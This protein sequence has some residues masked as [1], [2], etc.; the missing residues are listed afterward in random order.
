[1]D[2][3][4]EESM[5]TASAVLSLIEIDE[6]QGASWLEDTTGLPDGT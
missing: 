6:V 1:M 4:G 5:E 2:D 3:A